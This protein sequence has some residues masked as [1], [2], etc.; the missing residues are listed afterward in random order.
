[1]AVRKVI[2][3]YG[4]SPG[5]SFREFSN[6]YAASS[7]FEFRLPGY[8][9]REGFP[10]TVTCEFAEKAIMV[11]KAALMNDQGSF[12]SISKARTPAT[13]KQL[14]RKVRA[15]D[16]KL[17]EEHLRDTALEV[18]KQKFATDSRSRDVLLGTGDA[19]LA[20]A[21]KND[22]IWGIGL[23]VGDPRVQH[24]DKWL[25]RNVLGEALMRAR[26]FFRGEGVDAGLQNAAE[27]SPSA[28][29]KPSGISEPCT[30][31]SALP[32]SKRQ[33]TPDTA[34]ETISDMLSRPASS[35]EDAGAV[36]KLIEMG[37]TEAASREA[38][39]V[40]KSLDAALDHLMAKKV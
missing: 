29:A 23:D 16:Q 39:D 36:V 38:L 27:G 20:E 14:G 25:G 40:C 28:A 35:K 21:T 37:F 3:F 2:G 4:H 34:Q 18:V 24:P 26:G 22:R 10:H 6:F 9:Q 15:F 19:I 7:P 12:D 31:A 30:S 32:P 33:R 17:W 13:C 8:A 5:A 11:V 1:M